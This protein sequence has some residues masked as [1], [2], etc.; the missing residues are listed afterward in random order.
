M[1]YTRKRTSR[2]KQRLLDSHRRQSTLHALIDVFNYA[3]ANISPPISSLSLSTTNDIPSSSS[4]LLPP[5][6]QVQPNDSPHKSCYFSSF[7]SLSTSSSSSSLSTL[8]DCSD[9]SDN[10]SCCS[11]N[12]EI[13]K[14]TNIESSKNT[15]TELFTDD[16]L[17]NRSEPLTSKEIAVLLV[18]LRCRHALT[19]AC[20]THICQLLQVLKVPNAPSS[21]DSIESQVLSTYRSTIFPTQSTICP[22]CHQRSSNSKRCTNLNDCVSKQS[23]IRSPT[24]NYTFAIEPQV[25]SILERNQIFPKLH[26]HSISDITDGHFYKKLLRKESEPFVTLLMNS[27]GGLI[28]TI[29]KSIWCTTF[30][31]NELPRGIRFL[32]ENTIIGMV[33]TGSMKPKKDEMLSMMNDLVNELHKLEDGVSVLLPSNDSN[34]LEQVVRIFLIDCVCDKPATSLVLNHTECTGFFGCIY[35]TMRG[36]SVEVK[37]TTIRSFVHDP[38][39]KVILRSNK[40]YDNAIKFINNGYKLTNSN[41]ALS[42]LASKEYLQGV[43]GPCLLR[44][45]KYF[46]IYNSFLCDTLLNLYSGVM[47][48]MLKLFLSKQSITEGTSNAMSVYDRIDNIAEIVNSISYP[49]TTAFENFLDEE[50]FIHLKVLAFIAHLVEGE[51]LSSNAHNDIEFLGSADDFT[52]LRR[53]NDSCI[54]YKTKRS[55]YSIGFMSYIVHIIDRDE[56]CLVLNKVKITSTA[57]TLNIDGRN[58][59][60]NNILKGNVV[61]DSTVTIQ[62][63]QIS[64][65]VAFRPIFNEDPSLL[66]TFIFYQYPNLKECT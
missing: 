19:K 24:T 3:G 34:N 15:Y 52:I 47:G 41:R 28:K 65:K 8:S 7:A 9:K 42:K 59:M 4:L 61:S 29:S 36:K 33:S 50:R 39:E 30:V 27:D 62:P 55:S 43:R 25:R 48:K 10:D 51:C 45:L 64:K 16:D 12:N 38:N 49:S 22:S 18:Q 46:N 5:T 66:H 44:Q 63:S 31:I 14:S 40:T 2:S 26:H 21:F 54:L 57:D 53:S 32:P 35:C 60:C 17:Q 6:S 56:I 58:F 11:I 20:I 37:N 23:F 13:L 1:S